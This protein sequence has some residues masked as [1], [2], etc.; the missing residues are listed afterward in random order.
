[1]KKTIN[2][3]RILNEFLQEMEISNKSRNTIVNYRSDLKSF[4]ND[5]RTDIENINVEILRE[6]IKG[7][8]YKSPTTK[9]RHIS[10]LKMFLNWCYK[11]DFISVNPLLKI[12]HNHQ[13][14]S[15]VPRKIEKN[16]IDTVLCSINIFNK[17]NSINKNNLKYRLIFTLMLESGLKVYEVLG[18]EYKDVEVDMQTIFVNIPSNK[19]RVPLFSSESIKLFRLYTDEM[20]IKSGLIFKGGETDDK[21]LSYQALNKFWR[22]YCAKIDADIKLQQLR[23]CYA[24]ELIKK[25]INIC[26]I[27]KMLGHKN[28][29][30]TVKYLQ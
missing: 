27:S 9:A 18:L 12:E 22:K 6:H 28:L 25:G 16:D 21:S 24:N 14:T 20:N 13:K 4:M 23:D 10:S 1:M 19:R 11:K 5:C 8:E 26:I 7:L 30:T 15:F 29:Q 3:N 17:N 2:I